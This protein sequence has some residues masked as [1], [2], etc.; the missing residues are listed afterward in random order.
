MKNQLALCFIATLAF[1]SR[2]AVAGD[3]TGDPAES[4]AE[5]NALTSK[6]AALY[7]EGVALYKKGQW[8]DA[9]ASFLA[10]WSIHKHWQIAANLANVELKLGKSRDAAEHAAYYLHNAPADRHAR[11]RALLDKATANVGTLK[12]RVSVQGAEIAVDGHAVG[13]SP[14]ADDVIVDPGKHSVEARRDGYAA[15]QQTLI[16]GKGEARELTLSLTP[17][18]VEKRSI[19]P[20]VVLASTAGVA[21]VTGI[22][23]TVVSKGKYTDAKRVSDSIANAGHTCI[24]GAP[25]YDS[26]C[27]DLHSKASTSDAL[28]NAGVGLFVGAAAT[29]AGALTYFLWPAPGPRQGPTGVRVVPQASATGGGL[30]VSGAF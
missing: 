19:V 22:A 7:D 8:A 2:N 21:L 14:L 4:S 3:P 11:A 5:A 16:M 15:I 9:H 13:L 28:H 23:L 25:D 26:R 12:I 24:T 29:A 6:A 20:G 27:G 10:A 18:T 1:G 30:V 17:L